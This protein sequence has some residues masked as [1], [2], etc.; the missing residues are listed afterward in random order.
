MKA[1]S[2]LDYRALAQRRLPRFLFE[3]IDGG[4]YAEV[5]LRKNVADLE[6]IALRQRVL[7]DV[8]TIDVSTTL[9]GEA[10][11]LPVALRPVGLAGLS[12][13]RGEVQAARAAEQVG[14]PFCLSTVSACPLQE[15]VEGTRKPIWFQ[16]YMIRDRGFMRDLLQRARAHGCSAL[17]F[18]V[19]MPVPGARYR[20]YRSGLAG[21]PG[22]AGAIRRF[23]Q[24]VARPRWAW[25]V[26]IR[27]RPHNLGNVTPV[28][29]KN[30]GIEDFFAW[31]RNNFDPTVSWRDLEL[32]RS[33]WR[34]PLIVKG[35]LDAEDALEAQAVGAD[36]IVVS[37]HGGRQLGRRALDP[38]RIAGDR[39]QSG[40]RAHSACGWRSS[41]RARRGADVGRSVLAAFCWAAHGLTPWLRRGSAA[42]RTSYVS[43][44]LKCAWRWRLRARPGSTRS[45]ARSW[46][47]MSGLDNPLLSMPIAAAES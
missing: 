18:T 26:G 12:A 35:T 39:G 14:V 36:G 44:K 37:N 27:G 29:G 25:D 30:S 40:R 9:F 16:L 4:C 28:L 13:R 15:V 41:D 19:D 6:R 2:T 42:S 38:T 34:G 1:V 47:R 31:M 7:R 10:L 11:A 22:F 3:Y 8:S 5:T 21:A 33:E 45:I 23:M 43:S 46:L 20:D 17:V 32:I 24:G